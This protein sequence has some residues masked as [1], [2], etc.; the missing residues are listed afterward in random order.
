[1]QK[2]GELDKIRN[3]GIPVPNVPGLYQVTVSTYGTSYQNAVGLATLY[4]DATGFIG[5]SDW[6]NFDAKPWGTRSASGE[7]MTR[8]GSMLPGSPFYVIY[9]QTGPIS[10]IPRN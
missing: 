2:A 8:L 1:M 3:K 5:Y 7:I 4:Y 10:N 9:G 6:W